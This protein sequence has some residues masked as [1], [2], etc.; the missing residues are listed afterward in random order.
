MTRLPLGVLISGRGTN[1]AALLR[2]CED[3]SLHADVRVA[4][5]N[6]PS[7]EGLEFARARGV[8]TFVFPRSDYPDR[9]AQQTAMADCLEQHGVE[10]VVLAGFDQVLVPE[11]VARFPLRMINLHPSLLPA[12]S[13][14]M[15][16]VRDAL[17]AGVKVTGCTVHLVTDDLDGGPII[18]QEAVPVDQDDDE[19]SLLARVHEAE[20]V[21]LPA[22][23]Q[24]FAEKR[25][26]I[27][28]SKVRILSNAESF[29]KA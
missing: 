29:A 1:L 14:G 23:V 26:L 18:L 13:G 2:C 9:A 7:A 28:G 15:H 8:P 22:A 16:A 3:G 4:S 21:I 24:L 27:E 20:H 25:V 6:R 11:F 5:S 10:L 17:E 12:F 19:E